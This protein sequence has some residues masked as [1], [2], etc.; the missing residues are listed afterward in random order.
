MHTQRGR[1]RIGISGWR[2]APWRGVFYPK[3][4]TQKRELAYVAERLD[5]VE[6]NGTFYSLQRPSSFR[7]WSDEVPDD[8]VFALKGGRYITHILGLRGAETAL[9]NFFASGPL[10]LG[11]K[12]GPILWQLPPWAR[13]DADTLT[14]FLALLPR[15]TRDAALLAHHHD[16]RL[17]DRSWLET[18]ADRPIRHALEIRHP[19]FDDAAFVDLMREH[20]IAIVVADSAGRFPQLFHVTGQ[21]VY[22]RLHGAEELYVSGY[23]EELLAQWAERIDGW[24][25]GRGSP[26]GVP[27]DVYAYC[28]ND[29]KVRAPYDAERL[30]E[31]VDRL[32]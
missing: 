7:R 30:R 9:A 14:A 4:L 20:D 29:A 23:P 3:G 10:S 2:Y 28:D 31:L 15:T 13:F 21:I 27:R 25:T 22:V 5:T 18:D 24:L 16:E 26:D 17:D 32:A 12:L 19:S 8:F 11:P 6:I 1:A